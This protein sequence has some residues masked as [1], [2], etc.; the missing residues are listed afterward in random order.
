MISLFSILWQLNFACDQ[1]PMTQA[2]T[3]DCQSPRLFVIWVLEILR[4]RP[5][6]KELGRRAVD[7]RPPVA[8]GGAIRQ[9]VLFLDI[10]GH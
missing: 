10:R 3:G 8:W 9:K 4:A 7:N 1:C 5:T 2:E 6:R